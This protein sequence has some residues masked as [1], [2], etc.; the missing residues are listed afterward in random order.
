MRTALEAD[1]LWEDHPF[2]L[3]LTVEKRKEQTEEA[4][5]GRP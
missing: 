4:L 1:G 5:S 3:P 2:T